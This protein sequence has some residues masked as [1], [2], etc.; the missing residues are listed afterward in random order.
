M[1]L[2]C[3][4]PYVLTYLKCTHCKCEVQIK[5]PMP[6]DYMFNNDEEKPGEESTESDDN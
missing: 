1:E 4:M 2:Q 3:D 6:Y 5:Y